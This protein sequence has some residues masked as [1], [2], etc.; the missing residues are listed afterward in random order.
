[1][2][3][4]HANVGSRN[5][6]LQQ[7]PEILHPIGVDSTVNILDGVIDYL[8]LEFVQPVVRLKRIG[9]KCGTCLDVLANLGLH[10]FSFTIRDY[11]RADLA[12]ILPRSRSP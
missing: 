5:S 10:G 12:A 3:R 4:L 6:A 11:G 2:E 9:I 8:M 7:T 1:M